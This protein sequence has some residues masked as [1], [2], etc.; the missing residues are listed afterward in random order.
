VY[1]AG[2]TVNKTRWLQQAWWRYLQ[3]RW[4]Y[5]P[6]IHSWEL[7]NEGDPASPRHYEA[8]DEFGKFMHYGVFGRRPG[9]SFDHP[10]DHLVTTSFW[11]SFPAAAFWGS[12]QYP[13]VDYADLHAYVSTSFAPR[14][15]KE[16][17]QWDAAYYHTWHSGAVAAARIGKPV[18]RGEAGLDGPGRQDET[19]LGLQRDRTGVWLHNFL[20]STLDSG[21]LYELYWWRSHIWGPQG[22]HRQ[23]YRLL[24]RFLSELD[25][26]KGG[27]A[28]WNGTVNNPSLRVVGQKNVSAGTMHLWMQNRRHTWHNASGGRVIEPV[29]ADVGVS[30]FV[31]TAAYRVEW[32]DTWASDKA[33]RVQQVVADAS[34]SVRLIVT[35]LQTDVAVTL[36]R[37]TG[38]RSAS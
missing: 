22:D 7:V 9:A 35:A 12:G 8:A 28:D 33:V 24:G 4:G 17:M 21:G 37:N 6:S 5:S 27:Y 36:R 30:G 38:S 26:N 29:S 18:V 14:P 31:P 19:V 32:W 20:W 34:G 15:E 1:G 16:K 23:M 10:N 2:R 13:H 25:L 3:A 11:H